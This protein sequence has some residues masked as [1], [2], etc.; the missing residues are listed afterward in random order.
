VSDEESAAR[1]VGELIEG[2]RLL[3]AQGFVQASGGNLSVRTGADRMLISAT[4]TWLD[5]LRPDDF[6]DTTFAG[7]H[8]GP[9]PPSSE[10]LLHARVYRARPDAAAIIHLHPQHAL[11]LDAVGRPIRFITQDHAWYV[12]RYG[13]VPYLAAG[14]E[15]LADAVAAALPPG[16]DVCLMA[17]H[18]VAAIGLSVEWALRRALNFEEAAIMTYRALTLGDEQATFPGDAAPRHG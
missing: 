2:G 15:T 9:V 16:V 12:G 6:V 3:V 8:A 5:R 4:G 10:W 13:R 17:H 14:G 1:A 11:L 18:G 7:R